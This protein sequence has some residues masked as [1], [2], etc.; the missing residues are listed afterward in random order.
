MPQ[1]WFE[2]METIRNYRE[3]QSAMGR[4]NAWG[5][6]YNLARDRPFVGGGYEAFRAELFAYYAPDPEDVHD[7]HS[8]YFEVLGEHGFV[9]LFLFLGL[10]LLVWR[11]CSWI[12]RQARGDPELEGFSDL[13]RMTQVSL[14]G[15]AVGG[16]FLGLAYFDL[17]YN[18]VGIVILAKTMVGEHL[19]RKAASTAEAEEETSYEVAL[20]RGAVGGQ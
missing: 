3:D 12:R 4:I 16:A 2:R 9:G 17:Y 7:A 13:A 11:S 6:A 14:V 15:Y 8:I 18:L 20:P 1:K 19:R 10:G 5:F